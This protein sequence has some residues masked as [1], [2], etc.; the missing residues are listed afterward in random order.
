MKMFFFLVVAERRRCG[1]VT[2]FFFSFSLQEKFQFL[3]I[4]Q[5]PF[6][7]GCDLTCRVV[8]TV[9]SYTF[10]KVILFHFPGTGMSVCQGTPPICGEG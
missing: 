7:S 3:L 5:G 9:K 2:P 4:F 6:W 10:D 1:P 8:F